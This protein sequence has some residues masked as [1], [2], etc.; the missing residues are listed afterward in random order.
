MH[1]KMNINIYNKYIFIYVKFI[2]RHYIYVLNGNVKTI[3]RVKKPR[4][5]NTFIRKYIFVCQ[6]KLRF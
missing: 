1:H 2:L 3:W 5:M 6:C 4:K